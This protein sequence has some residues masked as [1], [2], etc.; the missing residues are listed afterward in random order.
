M[1]RIPGVH[2]LGSANAAAH[3]GILSFTVKDVH[4]HDV[5]EILASRGVAVRAGHHCAQPLHTYLSLPASVR[6]SF[7]FYNSFDDADRFLQSL[8]T[9]RGYMGYGNE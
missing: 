1:Q 4:P 9:V 5:A 6:V 2:V 3:H 7:A 8:R